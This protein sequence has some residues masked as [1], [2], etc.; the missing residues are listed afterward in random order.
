[1]ANSFPTVNVPFYQHGIK[2]KLH[3]LWKENP[4]NIVVVEFTWFLIRYLLINNSVWDNDILK[5]YYSLCVKFLS[6]YETENQAS[7]HHTSIH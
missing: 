1:M 2:G 5:L 6:D 4:K 7:N 3:S